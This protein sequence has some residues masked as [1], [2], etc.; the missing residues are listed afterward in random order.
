MSIWE[1]L[2]S[3][4]DRAKEGATDAAQ[5]ARIK[6]DIRSLEGRRDRLF[7]DIG[8]KVHALHDTA[9]SVPGTETLSEEIARIEAKIVE[10]QEELTAVG[11][12]AGPDETAD[13]PHD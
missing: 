6:L 10:K 5:T 4:L 11:G 9:A 7:R 2:R 8:R 3:L 13:R 1:G 12:R